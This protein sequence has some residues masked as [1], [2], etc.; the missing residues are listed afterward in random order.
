MTTPS[1]MANIEIFQSLKFYLK[2]MGIYEVELK[3]RNHKIPISLFQ[4]V[5]IL[6][7]TSLCV[8]TSI[9]YCL[10]EADSSHKF[11][12]SFYLSLG[13]ILV[14]IMYSVL[15]WKRNEIDHLIDEIEKTINN[16]KI[17]HF[18][19]TSISLKK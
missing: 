16:R 14:F 3:L 8:L 12:Q 9:W 17:R 1:A 2:L 6:F 11:I 15:L 5:S 7:Y 4:R 19:A 18:Y 10:F 13:H